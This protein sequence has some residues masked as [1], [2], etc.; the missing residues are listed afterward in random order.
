MVIKWNAPTTKNLCF[1]ASSSL[2][3]ILIN[4]YF[5]LDLELFCQFYL[6][7]L[8]FLLL[9]YLLRLQCYL[10]QIILLFQTQRLA[11]PHYLFFRILFLFLN[12]Y[13]FNFFIWQRYCI[14]FL[15][16]NFFGGACSDTNFSSFFAQ[17]SFLLLVQK[18][19]LFY[20]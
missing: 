4:Q 19:Y 15:F 14:W 5:Y 10:D 3:L 11:L 7:F 20:L 8:H 6:L 17:L 2:R 16:F 18:E 9:I 12:F 13:F 1:K